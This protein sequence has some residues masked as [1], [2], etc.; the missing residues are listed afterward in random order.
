MVKPN[1]RQQK[2][3]KELARKSK[4]AEKV[5]RRTGR[6]DEQAEAPATPPASTEAPPAQ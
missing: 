1:Y 6:T 4:Q 2:R 3:Q 5:Q